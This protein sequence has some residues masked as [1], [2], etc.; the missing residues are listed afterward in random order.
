M[1]SLRFPHLLNPPLPVKVVLADCV[2]PKVIENIAEPPVMR[3][4]KH[5]SIKE[6]ELKYVLNAHGHLIT[7]FKVSE[8][9][10]KYFPELEY[11]KWVHIRVG[12]VPE[13]TTFKHLTKLE[14]LH[15]DAEIV[16]HCCKYVASILNAPME[17]PE[18]LEN[19]HIMNIKPGAFREWYETIAGIMRNGASEDKVLETLIEEHH[20]VFSLNT[21]K[22]G[23]GD[24]NLFVS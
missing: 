20:D 18:T 3:N 15:L 23:I 7:E 5:L 6:R 8:Y 24:S 19:L 1:L 12:P 22:F 14:T 4:V 9:L 2:I 13:F 11:L 10:Q 16:L 17:F 21:L